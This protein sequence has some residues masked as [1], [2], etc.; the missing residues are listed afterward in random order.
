[1]SEHAEKVPQ[2]KPVE[3]ENETVII[4]DDSPNHKR[5][6]VCKKGTQTVTL[7][8]SVFY[9]QSVTYERST[10]TRDGLAVFRKA[11]G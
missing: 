1:M 6:V 2:A 4:L 5:E 9:A 3:A 8:P 10:D 7:G 11:N